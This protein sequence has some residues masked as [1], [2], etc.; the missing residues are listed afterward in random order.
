M[1]MLAKTRIAV[2]AAMLLSSAAMAAAAQ[3]AADSYR[4]GENSTF[5]TPYV[6]TGGLGSLRAGSPEERT[7]LDRSS[8]MF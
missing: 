1:T 8:R 2:A 3:S 5:E 6:P 7:L 4:P